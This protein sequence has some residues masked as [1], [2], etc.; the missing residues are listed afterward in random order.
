VVP[1]SLELKC[2]GLDAAPLARRSVEPSTRSLLG[3]VRH[4]ADVERSWSRR[5]MA[6]QD[7]APL[8]YSDGAP[9]GD[10]DGA[11]GDDA[12]VEEAWAAWRVEVAFATGFVAEAADL[13]VTGTTR[14]S[15]TVSLR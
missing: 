13:E 1:E 12:T 14:R 11:S 7:A 4:L 6:G 10:F 8:Y 5:T 15:T 2:S 9:D 3:L